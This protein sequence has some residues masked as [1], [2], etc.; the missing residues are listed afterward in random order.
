MF[1]PGAFTVS[2]D[3][4]AQLGDWRLKR[5][6]FAYLS[7]TTLT[8]MGYGDITPVSQPA[9]SLSWMEVM[10]GQFYMA[11]VVAQ[12]VGLKLA[13]AIGQAGPERR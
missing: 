3:I 9:Y 4:A 10:L 6:L 5:S 7:L 8:S 1:A 13:Q 11:V 12:L 2:S